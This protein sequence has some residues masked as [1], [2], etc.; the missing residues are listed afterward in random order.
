MDWICPRGSQTFFLPLIDGLPGNW[1]GSARVES[2]EWVTPGSPNI[3]PPRVQSVVMLEKWADAQRSVRREAAAYNAPTECTVF[4]W[5]LGKGLGGTQSGS[6]VIGI[7][8]IAKGNR[9]VTTELAITNV[10]PK[11]G[12]TDFAIFVYDQNGLIDYI[13]EVL[14]QKQVEYIDLNTYGWVPTNFLGSAV[15]SAVF[16][17]HD[18]FDG[19]RALPAERGGSGGRR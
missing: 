1:V 7:P 2:Q 19:E 13:C 15:I 3:D 4:D 5:Q 14:N 16:W 9:G 17:E 11:P 6:A 18:V 8:L 10:V 12:K